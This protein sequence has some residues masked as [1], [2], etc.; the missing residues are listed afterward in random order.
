MG[1]NITAVCNSANIELVKSIGADKVIDF[2]IN[3]FT[4]S[5]DKYSFVFD[6]VGKSSFARCKPLLD[7]GGIYISTE[8]GWM[9]QNIFLSIFTPIFGNKKVIFSI[10]SN[11]LKSVQLIQELMA[12]GKFKPVIYRRFKLEEISKAFK[13]VERGQKI[14][15]VIITMNQST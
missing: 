8:L 15:N 13:Y 2:T 3:D 12:N 5:N 11:Q 1:A 9:A 14:G 7:K 4:K 10:P 6:T